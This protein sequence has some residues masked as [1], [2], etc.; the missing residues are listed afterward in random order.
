MA[1]IREINRANEALKRKYNDDE[2]FVRVHKRIVEE[3][4][5]RK[6]RVPKEKPLISENERIVAE[7]LK[8]IKDDL[9]TQLYYNINLIYNQ[10]EFS[11]SV[12]MKTSYGLYDLGISAPVSDK[13]FIS[14]Q[15]INE[16]NNRYAR[17]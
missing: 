1:K 14:N 12:L 2:K 11:Q 16:Y 15:I 10:A 6:K 7:S 9:D 17:V 4:E 13:R 5:K 3:N 8:K